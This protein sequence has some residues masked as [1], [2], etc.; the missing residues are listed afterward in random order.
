[1]T[2]PTLQPHSH[3]MHMVFF[4]LKSP[5]STT[6]Q[7]AL[8]TGLDSLRSIDLIKRIH[9]GVP[10]STLERDVI[11]NSYQVSLVLEFD[12]IQDQDAY[13]IHPVHLAFVEKCQHLWQRVN[14]F[15]SISTQAQ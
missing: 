8:V 3:L 10:A 6:D 12:N 14:V 11:N 13:Q 9:I 2:E 4:W 5:S 15:D 7:K 1:M